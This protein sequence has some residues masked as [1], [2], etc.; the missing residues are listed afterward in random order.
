MNAITR[1]A[2]D[3]ITGTV[4]A[5][6]LELSKGS[7]FAVEP[8]PVENGEL[9]MIKIGKLDTIGRYYPNVEGVDWIVQPGLLIQVDGKTP[10]QV[11][12]PVA[13]IE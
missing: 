5:E 4:V 9:A 1:N 12:G 3:T 7:S 10:V 8:G 13:L 11:V 6:N 2:Q